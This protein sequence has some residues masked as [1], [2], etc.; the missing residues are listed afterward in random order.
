MK[1]ST[2]LRLIANARQAWR[3]WSVQAAALLVAWGTLPADM[4]AA[5]VAAVGIPAERVPAVLGL[6]VILGRIVQQGE[7]KQ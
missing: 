6:L 3:L 7:G 4:Q 5:L 1:I 2:R